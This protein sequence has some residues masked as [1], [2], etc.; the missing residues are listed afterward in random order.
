[1]P[2]YNCD[3]FLAESIESVI[4]Q[5]FIDWELIIVDDSSTDTSRAIA[6]RYALQDNRIKVFSNTHEKGL[7]GALNCALSHVQG[8]YIARADGDDINVPTRLEIQYRYLETHPHI[9]I[10]GS[11]YETFGNNKAPK[12]R[13]HPSHSMVLAWKYLSNTYFCHPTILLRKKVLE[14]VPEYPLVVCEDFAFL[15]Q[16]IHVHQGHNIPEVL[17]HYREH[18]NNYSSTKAVAIRESVFETFKKNYAFYDGNPTF[19]DV[20]Y[21]FHAQYRFSYKTFFSLLRQSLRIGK[22]IL[23]QYGLQ[24]NIW[25][26]IVLYSTIKI[27]FLKAIGNSIVRNILSK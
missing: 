4:A 26:H 23:A 20:F 25:A 24:K 15:S 6:E 10:V 27:H 13:K 22:H 21:R 11:W 17:L 9:D 18:A 8:A 2:V 16:V 7:A 19:V 12:V 14:T 3:A 5:T 1:M